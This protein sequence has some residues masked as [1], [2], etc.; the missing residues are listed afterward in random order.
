MQ[1]LVL[2]FTYN[3]SKNNSI[4]IFRLSPETTASRVSKGNFIPAPHRSVRKPFDLYGSSRCVVQLIC[5][6]YTPVG[7]QAGL[8]FVQRIQPSA[9][10]PQAHSF[11]PLAPFLKSPVHKAPKV[12]PNTPARTYKK[13]APRAVYLLRH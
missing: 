4:A 10:F 3:Y 13:P 8:H 7:K 6:A 11:V 1:I 5:G 9:T 12:V 2:P